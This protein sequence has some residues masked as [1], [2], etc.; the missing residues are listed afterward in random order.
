MS[1]GNDNVKRLKTKTGFGSYSKS[2]RL[3]RFLPL[4]KA[5]SKCRRVTINLDFSENQN[6]EN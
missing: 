1:S 2:A 4:K 6:C 5:T 3:A